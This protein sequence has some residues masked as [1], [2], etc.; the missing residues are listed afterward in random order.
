MKL[1][2]LA[3]IA[4]NGDPIVRNY[5]MSHY[6]ISRQTLHIWRKVEDKR[7]AEETVLNFIARHL[8]VEKE[9]LIH[10]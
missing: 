2:K 1:S 10:N 9:L 4:I 5:I 6:N 7:L 3:K 8:S